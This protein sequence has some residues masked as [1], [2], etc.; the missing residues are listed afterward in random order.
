MMKRMFWFGVGFVAGVFGS[1]NV[2]SKATSAASQLSPAQVASDLYDGAL[3]LVNQGVEFVNNL[4][5]DDN[6]AEQS[7]EGQVY[8]NRE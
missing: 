1:R 7:N 3:W 2:K 8:I 4:R 6:K 5:S